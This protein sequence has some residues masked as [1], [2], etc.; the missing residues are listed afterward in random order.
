[1]SDKVCLVITL[2]YEGTLLRCAIKIDG[3]VLSDDVLAFPLEPEN[4]ATIGN[5]L[6]SHIKSCGPVVDVE[7]VFDV[8]IL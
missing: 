8:C 6:P 2:F 3:D 4:R 1:M 7:Q 5:I